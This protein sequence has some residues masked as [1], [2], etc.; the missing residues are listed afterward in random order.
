MK[1]I[2]ENELIL[3]AKN[4]DEEAIKELLRRNG[5][6]IKKIA[7]EMFGYCETF[8]FDDLYQEGLIAFLKVIERYDLES[9]AK[10]S[11]YLYKY[12]KGIMLNTI[13]RNDGIIRYSETFYDKLKTIKLQIEELR[14]KMGKSLSFNE[15]IEN[16][17]ISHEDLVEYL[18]YRQSVLRFPDIDAF[19]A[20]NLTTNYDLEELAINEILVDKI[21]S[22][23]Y[24][25][26]KEKI[27]LYKMYYEGLSIR[28]V[29][30]EIN[31]SHNTVHL[32]HQSALQKIRKMIIKD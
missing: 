15:I 17:N 22:S 29:A 13:R 24:I 14:I 8:D 6:V 1:S 4:N 23:S 30:K 26:E 3:R 32:R 10:F 11:T 7:G 16:T 5:G 25:T 2:L 18:I 28:E 9:E 21:F 12:V 27:V 31:R 19:D 20:Y